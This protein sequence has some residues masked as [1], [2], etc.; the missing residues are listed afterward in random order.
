MI[1]VLAVDIGGTHFRAALFDSDGHPLLI[2][3]GTTEQSGG[4]DWMLNS[5]RERSQKLIG[6]AG[7]DVKACGISFG[8]PV[9]F[10]QQKVSSMHVAGWAGFELAR[11]GKDNL[12]LE[13]RVDNDANAGALGE[14]LYGAGRGIESMVYVTI[15]TGVG[16][17]VVC[18]GEVLRGKDSLA[19]EL[20]HIH[21]SDSGATCSCGG[22][23]C[24]EAICSGT[25]IGLRGRELAR[26]KPEILA[27]AIQ[28][29]F[30]DPER[31]TAEAIF[32]AATQGETGAVKIVREAATA[33]ARGIVS[34]V[35]ILNPDRIVLG[36][37]VALAGDVLLDPVHEALGE[38]PVPTLR[39]S[40]EVVLAELGNLSPLYGAAALALILT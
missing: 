22:Q 39:H 26:E 7:C 40:T 3:E 33:L 27:K 30:G 18:H 19:G 8:G 38:L 5:I 4:R 17:G 2:S 25:A 15:S 12:G 31:V 14:S 35:R 24:L 11:W 20:G 9:N 37:G 34:V 29:S 10:T 23:G 13:C 28:F 6:R 36:G 21:V 32:R 16:G 1:N